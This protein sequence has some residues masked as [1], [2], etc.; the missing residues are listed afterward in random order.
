MF[1]INSV[2]STESTILMKQLEILVSDILGYRW[3]RLLL[4]DSW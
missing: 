4:R 1:V 3:E 2:A